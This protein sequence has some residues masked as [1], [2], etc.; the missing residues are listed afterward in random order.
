MVVVSAAVVVIV[1][2]SVV[3][4]VVT[5]VVYRVVSVVV[6]SSFSVVDI[7]SASVAVVLSVSIR[8]VV[9][10]PRVFVVS[11][12]VETSDLIVCVVEGVVVGVFVF[13][14]VVVGSVL[15]VYCIQVF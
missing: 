12:C 6:V 9:V 14:N 5:V 13:G 15:T 10:L 2:V 1:V 8:S 7:F 4:V 11:E 3:C